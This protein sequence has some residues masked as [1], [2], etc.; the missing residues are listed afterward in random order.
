MAPNGVAFFSL[1]LLFL[2]SH[3]SFLALVAK[4]QRHVCPVSGTFSTVA[5]AVATGW[6]LSITL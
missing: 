2:H 6:L 4:H 1:L 3:L 5:V